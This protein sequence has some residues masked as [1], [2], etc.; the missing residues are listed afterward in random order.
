MVWEQL[1]VG[2]FAVIQKAD[3]CDELMQA[4]ELSTV[5][6]KAAELKLEELL[7]EKK[8]MIHT[9]ELLEQQVD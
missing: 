5:V 3:Q 1:R 7:A 6:G 9:N 2:Q 8:E 4:L